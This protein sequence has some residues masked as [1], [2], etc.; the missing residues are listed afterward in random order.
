MRKLTTHVRGLSLALMLLVVAALSLGT[1]SPSHAAGSA[2]T[3]SPPGPTFPHHLLT[4]K[5]ARLPMLQGNI[6]EI[7]LFAKNPQPQGSRQWA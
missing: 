7:P 5:Q 4:R 3:T 2:T 6:S 1:L